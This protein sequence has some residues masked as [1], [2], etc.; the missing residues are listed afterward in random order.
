LISTRPLGSGNSGERGVLGPPTEGRDESEK[1][2]DGVGN[3]GEY[4]IL[5]LKVTRLTGIVYGEGR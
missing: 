2:G 1:V 4:I 5:V 3:M